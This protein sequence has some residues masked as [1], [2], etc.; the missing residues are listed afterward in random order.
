MRIASSSDSSGWLE[1]RWAL[2]RQESNG[3]GYRVG[4]YAT[5]GE[6]E[7]VRKALEACGDAQLYAIEKIDRL[8]VPSSGVGSCA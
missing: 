3:S 2:I 4:R 8:Q 5:R 6:A 7:R 1:L